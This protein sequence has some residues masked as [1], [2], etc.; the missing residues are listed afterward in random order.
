MNWKKIL[1]DLDQNLI[2][3]AGAHRGYDQIRTFGLLQGRYKVD[4]L[5][6]E[7][8]KVS[9]LKGG[10]GLRVVPDQRQMFTWFC[11]AAVPAGYQKGA[12][13]CC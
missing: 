4:W 11:G 8:L 10:V 5:K 3:M 12:F 2:L 1:H 9:T 13:C 7:L 6:R